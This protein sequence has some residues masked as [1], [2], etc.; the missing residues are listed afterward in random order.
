MSSIIG[1]LHVECP[2]SSSVSTFTQNLLCVVQQGGTDL[3]I[4][5]VTAVVTSQVSAT[6]PLVWWLLSGICIPR[7]QRGPSLLCRRLLL[8]G[9]RFD[10]SASTFVCSCDQLVERWKFGR[11]LRACD[12]YFV[13]S[14]L[15]HLHGSISAGVSV[16]RP[17]IRYGR[18]G[19]QYG[20]RVHIC[21]GVV[22]NTSRRGIEPIALA[23]L[24]QRRFGLRCQSSS[25]FLP[26]L[27]LLLS[28]MLV[29]MWSILVLLVGLRR[30]WARAHT[31]RATW[32]SL[33]GQQ[34]ALVLLLITCLTLDSRICHFR[35]PRLGRCIIIRIALRLRELS[36]VLL[37][38]PA[39]VLQLSIERRRRCQ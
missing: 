32:G 2:I 29:I 27:L 30:R 19:L 3:K 35:A 31:R 26:L 16:A 6:S 11:L 17:S 22:S 33:S 36:L 15:H 1:G 28:C 34:G 25:F 20:R 38:L 12:A 8:Q 7:S 18:L 13:A 4:P 23:T 9:S 10:W 39:L 24:L 37:R 14:V 21:G 5:I